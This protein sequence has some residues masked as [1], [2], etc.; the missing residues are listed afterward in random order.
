MVALKSETVIMIGALLAFAPQAL[1]IQDILKDVIPKE[2]ITFGYLLLTAGF[3]WELVS[4]F[5]KN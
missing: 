4:S 1:F 5:K 3:V 2:V